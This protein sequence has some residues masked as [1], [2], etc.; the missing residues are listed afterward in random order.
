[1]ETLSLLPSI[2]QRAPNLQGLWP[3]PDIGLP[4]PFCTITWLPGFCPDSWG[5]PTLLPWGLKTV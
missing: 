4:G 5:F 2:P 1:M 3:S